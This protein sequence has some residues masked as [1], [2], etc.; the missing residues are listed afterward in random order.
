[1]RCNTIDAIYMMYSKIAKV[2]VSEPACTTLCIMKLC[3]KTTV[4]TY[5][6]RSIFTD[7]NTLAMYQYQIQSEK[8]SRKEKNGSF[9]TM[10]YSTML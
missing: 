3:L 9:Q 5:Y 10:L 4:E 7:F 2:K 6:S 8:T 1:M